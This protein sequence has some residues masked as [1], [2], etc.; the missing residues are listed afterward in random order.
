MRR[1]RSSSGTGVGSSGTAALSYALAGAV[2]DPPDLLHRP[3]DVVV[4]HDVLVFGRVLHL[5][6]GDLPP[7]G[8]V[9]GRLAPA[10]LLAL[11]QL[12]LGGRHHEDRDRVRHQAAHLLRSLHVDLQHHVAALAPRLL[13]P[14]AEGAVQVAVVRRVLEERTLPD[15][16]FETLPGQ[17]GVVLVRLL[18]R[19]GL[20]SRARDRVDQVRLH[21]E[22]AADQ[23]VLADTGRAR[24]DDQQ[25][26]LHPTD[27]QKAWKSDGGATSKLISARVRGCRRRSRHAW[28]MGR[29]TPSSRPPYSASPATG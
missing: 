17:E 25:A 9:L 1:P 26:A 23:R 20:A 19:P 21:L 28:S 12:V 15:E 13:D 4:G 6:L 14:V 16:L 29:S 3:L 8:Q 18:A 24:D 27:S 22:E 11:F 2:D 5:S 7:R 10:P